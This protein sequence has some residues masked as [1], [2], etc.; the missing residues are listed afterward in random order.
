L[1]S[2]SLTDEEVA[3]AGS[4]IELFRD[5]VR[6]LEAISASVLVTSDEQRTGLVNSLQA[7]APTSFRVELNGLAFHIAGKQ[8]AMPATILESQAATIESLVDLA[9]LKSANLPLAVDLRYSANPGL[10][11]ERLAE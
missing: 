3:Q 9:T 5:G 8:Y 1:P 10:I 6:T 2:E 11:T 4:L 7:E